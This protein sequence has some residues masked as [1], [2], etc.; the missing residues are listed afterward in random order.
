MYSSAEFN[1]SR[2]FPLDSGINGNWEQETY[3]GH[4][5]IHTGDLD[6][7]SKGIYSGSNIGGTDTLTGLFPDWHSTSSTEWCTVDLLNIYTRDVGLTQAVVKHKYFGRSAYVVD[8]VDLD[9][10]ST[11]GLDF[12][13]LP[14]YQPA[15][16]VH[17]EASL[18]LGPE[19]IQG[20]QT[21]QVSSA[22]YRAR[23][24]VGLYTTTGRGGLHHWPHTNRNLSTFSL[25]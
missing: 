8:V 11:S 14:F 15:P 9:P 2:Q 20:K 18:S 13:Y 3:V 12:I 19:R 24:A 16:T 23:P 1:C 4:S 17:V 6:A 10:S 25:G 21:I 22:V 7:I 5:W